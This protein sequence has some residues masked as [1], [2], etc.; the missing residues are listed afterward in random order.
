MSLKNNIEKYFNS[1]SV[2]FFTESFH[3]LVVGEK[4]TKQNKT[5]FHVLSEFLTNIHLQ[6]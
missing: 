3:F 4:K 5:D 1:I 2:F 6:R